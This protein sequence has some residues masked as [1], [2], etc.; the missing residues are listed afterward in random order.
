MQ[1][2]FSHFLALIAV[3]AV[4]AALLFSETRALALAPAA[5]AFGF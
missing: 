1:I 5:G 3:S 2:N 4:C